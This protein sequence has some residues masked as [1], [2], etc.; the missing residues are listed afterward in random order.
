VPPKLDPLMGFSLIRCRRRRPDREGSTQF[1]CL[2][3]MDRHTVFSNRS[4]W[5]PT[6]GISAPWIEP[7]HAAAETCS[8]LP[9]STM[10]GSAPLAKRTDTMENA[11]AGYGDAYASRQA[12]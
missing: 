4:S 10:R 8:V 2:R 5:S 9:F 11:G 6:T 3:Q 1:L 12:G 7:H